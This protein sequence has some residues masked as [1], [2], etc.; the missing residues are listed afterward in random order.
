MRNELRFSISADD[1]QKAFDTAEVETAYEFDSQTCGM[2]D[3][4]EKITCPICFF[5]MKVKEHL[6]ILGGY[7]RFESLRPD[8]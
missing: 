3:K 7:E 1:L 8:K 6:G 4:E 5:R 2:R